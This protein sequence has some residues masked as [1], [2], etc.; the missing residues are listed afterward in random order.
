MSEKSIVN[1]K[2]CDPWKIKDYNNIKKK[3]KIGVAINRLIPEE[4]P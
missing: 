3:N 4:C 1:R 2:I